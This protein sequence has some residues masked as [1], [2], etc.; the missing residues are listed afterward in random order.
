MAADNYKVILQEV[1]EKL[2][3]IES[4]NQTDVLNIKNSIETIENL[5]S[6]TQAK[7]NFQDIKDKLE[8]ISNQVVNCNDGILKDLFND[9]NSLSVNILK[10]FKIPKILR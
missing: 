5:M 4:V 10:I 9:I 1:C 2:N 7:L 8:N 3:N 6:D